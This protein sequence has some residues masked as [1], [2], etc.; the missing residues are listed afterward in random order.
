MCGDVQAHHKT[1]RPGAHHL[2]RKFPP[3]TTDVPDLGLFNHGRKRNP[4][5]RA[6]TA[7]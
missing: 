7:R 1:G 2:I 4:V 5:G 3:A 6:G